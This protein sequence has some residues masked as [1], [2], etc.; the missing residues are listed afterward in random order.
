MDFK[1][2]IEA[3]S[4]IG[5]AITLNGDTYSEADWAEQYRPVLQTALRIADRCASGEV[6]NE[7]G[8]QGYQ[9]FEDASAGLAYRECFKAMAAQLVKEC[10]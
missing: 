5:N 1:N 9:A 2:C 8:Y 4:L 10:E 7:M 6:S 3:Y